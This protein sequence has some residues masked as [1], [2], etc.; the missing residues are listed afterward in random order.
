[1][2]VA[3]DTQLIG[4]DGQPLP[5][6]PEAWTAR[7]A[8]LTALVNQTIPKDLID[9]CLGIVER[10]EG[11][12]ESEIELSDDEFDLVS[13]C[14]RNGLHPLLY[15]RVKQLKGIEVQVTSTPEGSGG[16]RCG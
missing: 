9:E 1:M 3:L 15:L 16:I 11:T 12:I 4:F 7:S 13:A 5:N 10:I 2:R 14:A 8:I 6:G